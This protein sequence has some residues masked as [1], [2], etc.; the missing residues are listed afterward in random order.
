M[1]YDVQLPDTMDEQL[2][3][4]FINAPS[5]YHD[6]PRMQYRNR[7]VSVA[8]D[9]ISLV[10]SECIS[11]TSAVQKHARS[12]HSSVSAILGG[13]PNSIQL[14]TAGPVL[15]ARQKSSATSVGVGDNAQD[16]GSVNN[17]WGLRGQKG[18]SMQDNPMIAAFGRLRHE[19]AAVK[20]LVTKYHTMWKC[21]L[22]FFARCPHVRRTVAPGTLSSCH[23]SQG[24]CC[25]RHNSRL[26]SLEEVF[27]LWI[28]LRRVTKICACHAISVCCCDTLPV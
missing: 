5:L 17:R 15:K 11:I 7:P 19:I 8:V 26:G 16:T 14:G 18:K 1:S 3:A 10:I 2:T 6:A 4:E 25:S 27:S 22:T 24:N 28:C 9:P 21:P 20:G 23:S 12:P 13:N